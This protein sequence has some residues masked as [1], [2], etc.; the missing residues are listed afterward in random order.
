LIELFI[1]EK[2][3]YS[4]LARRLNINKAIIYK[5]LKNGE[6][7]TNKK[8]RKKLFLPAKIRPPLPPKVK[9]GV[10]ILRALEAKADPPS[11]RTYR[12]YNS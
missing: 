7:P 2:R 1:S 11:R 9:R 4:A 10:E 5:F 3:V 8:L 12:R 6:E